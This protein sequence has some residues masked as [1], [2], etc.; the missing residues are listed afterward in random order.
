MMAHRRALALIACL[1]GLLLGCPARA[2]EADASAEIGE[3]SNYEPANP[4]QG[5]LVI[6]G[7]GISPRSSDEQLSGAGRRR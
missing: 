3:C 7:G 5:S 6:C 4:V 2:D 1:L